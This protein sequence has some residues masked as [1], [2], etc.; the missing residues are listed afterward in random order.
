MT[1]DMTI[2]RNTG[3]ILGMAALAVAIAALVVAVV[4]SADA[5]SHRIVVRKGQLAP[6]SVTA[7][8]LA[9]GAVH[10]KALAKAAV[11]SKALAKGAVNSAAIAGGAV[12]SDALANG[13]VGTA[14]LAADAVTA[15]Q[16][17]PGSVYG[18][19]L[20]KIS[21]QTKTIADLDT[22]AANIEWTTSNTE[23]ALC[24]PG[25]RVIGGGFTFT[26]PG[27]REVGWLQALPIQN[28]ETQGITGR[29]TSN[30]GGA[31]VGEIAAVCLK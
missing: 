21:V 15:A 12:N 23:V 31:A 14:A 4:G 22:T 8:A 25:E 1:N 20:G 10:P 3:T 11:H 26:N 5:A 19:A 30:A 2:R 13:A 16:I 29:F 7:K 17:A 6:G 27:N 18:G 28:G 9:R 24:G